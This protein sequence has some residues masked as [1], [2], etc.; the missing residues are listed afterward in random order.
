M[1]CPYLVLRPRPGELSRLRRRPND[2]NRTAGR[3][4]APRRTA[5]PGIAPRRDRGGAAGTVARRTT[6]AR[7]PRSVRGAGLARGTRRRRHAGSSTL[8][9]PMLTSPPAAVPCGVDDAS[10]VSWLSRLSRVPM[11]DRPRFGRLPEEATEERHPLVDAS[12]RG[13]GGLSR[14][15]ADESAVAAD[16]G[17]VVGCLSVCGRPDDLPAPSPEAWGSIV[18]CASVVLAAGAATGWAG[19]IPRTTPL[20]AEPDR[21]AARPLRAV[22]SA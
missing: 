3:A 14:G 11:S 21:R 16:F 20:A 19:G 7:R 8:R 18:P 10:V 17:A 9:S 4:A 13:A 5:P 6:P 12:T 2:V 1:G 22:P 15:V